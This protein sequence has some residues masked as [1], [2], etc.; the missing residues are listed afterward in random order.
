[1]I[2]LDESSAM[3][4]LHPLGTIAHI[5]RYPIKSL[6]AE[7]LESV[8]CDARGLAGDRRRALFV[9]TPG[10]ARDGKAYRGKENA[11]LHTLAEADDAI[12]L[13]TARDITLDLR[14][15][16][17]FFDLDPIS[18]LLDTWLRDGERVA[19]RALEPLRFRPNV[20][21]QAAA[22]FSATENALVDRLLAIGDVRLRVSQPIRR[23]VT[24]TY[25]LRT[26]ESDPNVLAAIARER[27]NTMGIY[28]HVIR[29][30]CI[31]C[32]DAITFARDR[33]A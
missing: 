31:R 7:S 1:M 11:L 14:D 24:T 15:D 26:G 16:G 21:V 12:S 29:P 13:G 10:H 2:L 23:C 22:G 17:P 6:T 30:G 19:A 3:S 28:A 20:F 9:A 5:W 33:S 18:L 25:D 4:E 8:A 32:G 27:D